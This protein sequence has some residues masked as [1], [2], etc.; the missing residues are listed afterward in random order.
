MGQ[1]NC[2]WITWFSILT[3]FSILLSARREG[4]RWSR[5]LANKSAALNEKK[6]NTNWRFANS[7]RIVIKSRRYLYRHTRHCSLSTLTLLTKFFMHK[8]LYAFHEIQFAAGLALSQSRNEV[9][10]SLRNAIRAYSQKLAL[11][12]A[13]TLWSA[14]IE[15][16]AYADYRCHRLAD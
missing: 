8:P 1:Y 6:S 7:P 15:L 16:G 3:S 13:L 12:L 2:I 14:K 5:I 11:T 10:N 9:T 4:T